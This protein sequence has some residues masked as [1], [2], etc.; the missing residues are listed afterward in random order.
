M[1]QVKQQTSVMCMDL[2]RSCTAHGIRTPTTHP[3]LVKTST[4]R[5]EKCKKLRITT[6]NMKAITGKNIKF[7]EIQGKEV[8]SDTLKGAVVM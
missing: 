1:I 8:N 5:G 6:W 7:V 2:P 4:P 3:K